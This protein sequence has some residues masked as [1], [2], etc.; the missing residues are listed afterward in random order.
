MQSV[1]GGRHLLFR[2]DERWMTLELERRKL[3]CLSSVLVAR[4]IPLILRENGSLFELFP[5]V[6]PEPVLAKRSFLHDKV[7]NACRSFSS[8][9]SDVADLRHHHE[10]L[11]VG[12]IWRIKALLDNLLQL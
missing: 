7:R 1:N 3:Q 9:L 6:C 10:L 5:Y 4:R 8:H 2:R 11:D 12:D